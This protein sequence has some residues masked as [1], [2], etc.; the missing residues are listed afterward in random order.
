MRLMLIDDWRTI[1]RHAWSIRLAILAAL[2]SGVEIVLPLFADAFPRGL[3]AAMSF[4]ATAA[5][6][7][8]RLIAQPRMRG[9]K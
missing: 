2:L 3:F 9:D 7:V 1:L 6:T 4:V 5:A 8:A